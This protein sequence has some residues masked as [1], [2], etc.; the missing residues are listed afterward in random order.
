M[1]KPWRAT[2]SHA[3]GWLADRPVPRAARAPL[4]RAYA[5]AT[6]ADLSESR[7]PL[8]GYP[9][10]SA[11]FVRRL[12]DGARTWPS[13]PEVF[14]SPADGRLQNQGIV[15]QG[16]LLQAKGQS[17]RVGELIGDIAEPGELDSARA[18]TVY[19]SPRDYHRV[20]CP[21]TAKL[22]AA[23]WQGGDRFSVAP[24]ELSNRPRVF[25]QNERVA[26]RMESERG[27]YFLVLVGALNVGRLRVVGLEP[28]ARQTSRKNPVFQRG[29]ELGR[30]ELGSTV[31]VVWPG[32]PHCPEPLLGLVEGAPL[33]MGEPLARFPTR[34]P[35]SEKNRHGPDE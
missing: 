6:G 1:S 21:L 9:N 20:H 18:W 33:K 27:P 14:P 19:L 10:L 26:L 31:V 34:G 3:V 35:S 11:F 22:A 13:A 15:D 29:E 30:F 7:P 8:D 28:L 23:A 25:V 4:Y 16:S 12:V 32:G 5:R 2:V 17:Y 24:R